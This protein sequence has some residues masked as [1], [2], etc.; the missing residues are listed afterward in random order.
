[1]SK[2]TSEQATAANQIAREAESM[3]RQASQVAAAVVEQTR[4]MRET[5]DAAQSITSQVRLITKANQDHASAADS[6]RESLAETRFVTDRNAR[7]ATQT[8][9]ATDALL[10]YALELS[11]IM[12][13][14][15]ADRSPSN[16]SPKRSRKS[17]TKETRKPPQ[18][19]SVSQDSEASVSTTEN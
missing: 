9:S 10:S 3:K 18:T 8:L 19:D 4:A 7:T 11:N 2:A 12:D 5:N 6:I 1:V 13:K 14:V 15:D 16:G 17:S